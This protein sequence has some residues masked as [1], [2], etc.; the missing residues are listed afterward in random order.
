MT[1]YSEP[2]VRLFVEATP[3][4]KRVPWEYPDEGGGEIVV[5][6][7]LTTEDISEKTKKDF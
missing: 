7:R 4:K 1:N 5:S 6:L 3:D 2:F